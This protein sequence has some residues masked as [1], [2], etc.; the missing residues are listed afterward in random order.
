MRIEYDEKEDIL[1]IRFSDKPIVRDVSHGW[2][3][4][5]GMSQEGIAQITVLNA[6][7]DGFLPL[8]VPSSLLRD[9]A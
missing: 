2:N 3:V 1:F 4:V 5:V 7:K 8:E 9:A 6:K